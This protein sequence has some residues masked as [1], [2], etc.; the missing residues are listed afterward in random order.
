FPRVAPAR[1]GRGI[2]THCRGVAPALASSRL[3][4]TDRTRS[5]R[6]PSR[7]NIV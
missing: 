6:N 2:R 1:G 7:G 5:C 3:G 4:R